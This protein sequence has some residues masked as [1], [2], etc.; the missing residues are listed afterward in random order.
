MPLSDS[1]MLLTS[2][3]RF[4]PTK[5]QRE[6]SG[7]ASEDIAAQRLAC[8]YLTKACERALFELR[9]SLAAA[10]SP[11]EVRA[12]LAAAELLSNV[13]LTWRETYAALGGR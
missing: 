10:S 13:L 4:S 1:T 12:G 11:S 6:R 5:W 9:S 7:L 2:R 3:P 8:T